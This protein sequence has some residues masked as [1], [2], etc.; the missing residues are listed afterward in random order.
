MYCI[1]G[2]DI[3]CLVCRESP[4]TINSTMSCDNRNYWCYS[5]MDNY[6]VLE[7]DECRRLICACLALKLVMIATVGPE[8]MNL[9]N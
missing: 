2:N 9:K 5:Y 7:V 3:T 1:F 6:I 8:S 4:V